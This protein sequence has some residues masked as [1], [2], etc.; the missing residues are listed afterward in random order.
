MGLEAVEAVGAVGAVGALGAVGNGVVRVLGV[1][2]AWSRCDEA[3]HNVHLEKR[4]ADAVL[5]GVDHLDREQVALALTDT[6][7]GRWSCGRVGL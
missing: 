2:G 5:V 7:A 1:V 3:G 4:A 6:T